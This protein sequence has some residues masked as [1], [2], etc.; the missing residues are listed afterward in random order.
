MKKQKCDSL[1]TIAGTN[2]EKVELK[3]ARTDED[4][5]QLDVN[6]EID[7]WLLRSPVKFQTVAN[8]WTDVSELFGL[9][10]G[11]MESQFELS[12]TNFDLKIY[13]EQWSMQTGFLV[14]FCCSSVGWAAWPS[15]KKLA[16]F[17]LDRET[18]AALIRGGFLLGEKQL[19]RFANHFALNVEKE[20][21][22]GYG[23]E[24]KVSS[25]VSETDK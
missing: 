19:E 14:E 22:A 16:A 17:L 6:I 13:R 21:L 24:T 23:G 15:R 20:G 25:T 11:N 3:I 7:N 4:L 8:G 18:Y 10:A 12:S 9:L 1:S 2:G 5:V